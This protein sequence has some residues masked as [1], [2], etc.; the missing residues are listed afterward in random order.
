MV[1]YINP[2]DS[3]EWRAHRNNFEN[4]VRDWCFKNNIG[5]FGTYHPV[6]HSNFDK[7]I[8]LTVFELISPLDYLT[9]L[10]VKL[11]NEGKHLYYLTDNLIDEEQVR[12]LKNITMISV[13]ELFGMISINP[14]ERSLVC[15][16]KLFNCFIQRVDTV[17]QTWFYFLK[18]YNLLDKGYVS[19][20]LFQYPFYSDKTGID[21]FDYNHQ[22]GDLKNL[23]NFEK[24]YQELRSLVPYTNFKET[25]NLLQY[26]TDSKYSLVL[27]TYAINDGHIGTCYTEKI[28]R[29]LQAPTVNLIFSQ[30]HSLSK[31]ANLGFKFSECMLEI[32]RLPWIQRQQNLLDI[33]VN[34][35][36]AF[37]IELLY[38][39]A[40]HN[41]KLIADYKM[42]FLNGN[43]LDQILTKIY[44]E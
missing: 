3:I 43:Y 7:I 44:K 1:K 16:T 32:D 11:G 10:D 5:F 8:K 18:N 31:L 26:I 34:D 17:R 13:I 39:N 28:H 36:V 42:K 2:A 29:A 19:F 20:L 24:A 40:L 37:D 6:T 35:S 4:K 12:C 23:E 14:V 38:N 25:G 27:E 22:W 30:Q 33:L 9:D 21:L 41:Q 15:P